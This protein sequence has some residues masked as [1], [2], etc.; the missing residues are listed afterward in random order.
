[1]RPGEYC[2]VIRFLAVG[3]MIR[4]KVYARISN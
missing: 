4:R 1:L 3:L 2:G